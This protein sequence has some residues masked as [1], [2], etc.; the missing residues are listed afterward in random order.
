M[1]VR[2]FMQGLG[3]AFAMLVTVHPAAAEVTNMPFDALVAQAKAV[4]QTEPMLAFERAREAK[5]RA[6]DIQDK[7]EREKAEAVADWLQGDALTRVNDF[8]RAA[9]LVA[10]ALYITRKL[11]K[12]SKLEGDILLA[13]GSINTARGDVG[14]ALVD[15]QNAHENYHRN[16]NIRGRAIALICI[17]SLYSDANDYSTALRYMDQ[18]VEIYQGDDSVLLSV[19][20]NRASILQEFGRFKEA[21]K[22]FEEALSLSQKMGSPLLQARIMGNIARSRMR[23]RDIVTASLYVKQAER[24]IRSYQEAQAWTPQILAIAAQLAFERHNYND[25][26]VL[27]EKRFSHLNLE[28][29]NLSLRDAHQTAYD[30]YRVLGEFPLALTHLTALRRL[31]EQ[32]TKL[33]TSANTA[34]LAARFDYANQELRIANLKADDL[35]R[36]VALERERARTQRYLFAGAVG[37][38]AIIIVALSF[39]LI[40]VRR[41]NKKVLAANTD[42]A[43]ANTA[44]GKA[45]ATKTEFLATT[46]HE[47]RTPLNGILGMTQVMLADRGLA[48]DM[49]G[50]LSIVHAA[51]ETMRALVD[52][53]LDVAKIETG[54]L[55]IEQ[56]P[57]DLRATIAGVIPM[58]QD[59]A[60]GKEVAFACDLEDCP[61]LIE[62]DAARVRQI[63]FNLLSNALKF[64]SRGSVTLRVAADASVYRIVVADTG[65]GI[66]WDKLDEIFESFRQADAGT[67]RQFGGTGLGL[68]ICRNLADAMGGD[69]VVESVV[70]N[71]SAFTVTLPLVT[72]QIAPGAV[73]ED[74]GAPALL[75]VDRNPITRSMFRTLL[76]PHVEAVVHA[77]LID[78]V[79]ARLRD[80]A[81]AQVLL[82]EATLRAEPDYP[83][84][85]ERIAQVARP[86]GIRTTLL[87]VAGDT[88]EDLPTV[89]L[90]EILARPITGAA[91]IQAMFPANGAP[92]PE[93]RLVS[94]AA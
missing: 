51:G 78:D 9:P 23:A 66:A 72:T 2:R 10:H 27:I 12:G 40:T 48:S 37:V 94:Q 67:T 87:R 15:Y 73:A 68:A 93:A 53:I 89:G 92:S 61:G 59:Q 46:S 17:G 36:K 54:N 32:A 80:D 41:S 86:R 8:D 64:T 24:I 49:R 71:G 75:I 60:R 69:I 44:L 35:R 58:W 28:T 84:T 88:A 16:G 29:T 11:A 81:I 79:L 76:A 91:L 52:D 55:T 63:V 20:N 18:A 65:I 34:L 39:A 13:S 83:Q 25:A 5:G 43:T 50:R 21:Q 22:Q 82:D 19:Y 77:H 26:K 90:D 38:T 3:L 62:G 30:T 6:F 1:S 74:N 57:F 45:L 7:V 56:A 42:L 33:A 47:I 85:L 14:K 4:M 70:G 31:D